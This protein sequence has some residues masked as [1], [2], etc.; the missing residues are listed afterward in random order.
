MKSTITI[1]TFSLLFFLGLS[2]L[3]FAN[4]PTGNPDETE[5]KTIFIEVAGKMVEIDV[6]EICI[7]LQCGQEISNTVSE[8]I[9]VVCANLT[10][11]TVEAVVDQ[12][13][14]AVCNSSL[15][16]CTGGILCVDQCGTRNLTWSCTNN[17]LHLEFEF[18]RRCREFAN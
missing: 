17:I 8:D 2:A 9:P 3:L 6:T 5:P 13:R 10:Q 11:A 15:I 18:Y 16:C 7:E 12:I 14:D 4:Q 1:R